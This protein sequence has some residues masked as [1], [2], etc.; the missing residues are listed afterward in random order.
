MG[1]SRNRGGVSSSGESP[2][3]ETA[4]SGLAFRNCVMRERDCSLGRL[5]V[6]PRKQKQNE[7]GQN[8]NGKPP[9][10]ST[11]DAAATGL[12]LVMVLFVLAVGLAFYV[13][14]SYCFKRIC[15]KTG[16]N[17]GIL[18]WIPI[19]QFIPLL[20]VAGMAEWMIILLLI[21]IANIVVMVMMWAK[22]CT[23]RGKSPWLVIMLFI[24]IV[25][26]AFLPYLAFSE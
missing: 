13:F 24:P 22:I 9:V 20:R 7:T 3:G 4:H 10:N 1:E 17:P 8:P 14:F 23:A 19:V 18:I 6:S 26:I 16:H 2:A 11:Q 5:A 21:P 25:D 15:E 12:G